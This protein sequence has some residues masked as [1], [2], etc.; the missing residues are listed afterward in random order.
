L[1][2]GSYVATPEFLAQMINAN[3]KLG[4][5]GEVFF[6][7]AGIAPREDFFLKLY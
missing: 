6:H 3:R 7:Y 1:K 2:V 4:V 5:E